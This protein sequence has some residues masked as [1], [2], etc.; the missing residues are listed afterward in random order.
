MN[1][2]DLNTFLTTFGIVGVVS[3]GREGG[4]DNA[5][6]GEGVSMDTTQ[7]TATINV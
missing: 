5:H 1:A 7:H 3:V 4:S 2:A 6:A